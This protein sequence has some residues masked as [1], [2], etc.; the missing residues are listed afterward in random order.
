MTQEQLTPT[1]EDLE[2]LSR[3]LGR[4]A[5][6]VVEIG[7]RCVCGNPLVATTAPRLSNGIP[8][9]TTYYLAHPVITAAVSRLEAAGVMNEMTERLEQDPEL[10]ARYRAAHEAYLQVRNDIGARTG[11]GPVPEID[12]VS[13]GGMPTRV[14]CLHVL[15]GHSL[16]AGP[17]VNPLGDEALERISPWWTRDRCYCDGAWDT[18]AAAPSRDLSRHTKTQGLSAEELDA[19]RAAR[20]EAVE[21]ANAEQQGDSVPDQNEAQEHTAT[22]RVAAVDCGTNSIRLLI[23]DVTYDGGVPKLTDVVRLMRVNRLGQGVDATGRLAPEALE[24]TFEAADEYAALIREH[25]AEQVRFVAT[26]ASRDAENRSEFVDGIRARLGVEPEVI[27]GDEE[28]ALSFAGATSVL[29]G[30]NGTKTLV[31]DLGGGSTEFVLG[32]S[33]GVLAAKST[34]MGCV[35]FTERHLT[36]NPPTEAEIAV[37]RGDI[38]DMIAQVLTTVPLAEAHRLVGVAGTITTVTAHALHLPE[39]SAEAIHGTELDV[40]RIDQAADELLHMDRD[41]R[42]AL[43][44]MHP[45]RVDVIGAGALIWQTIVDRVAELTDGSV[46]TAVTSEHDILDG[47][48]L[49]AAR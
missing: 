5:R 15:V 8:F 23:A 31:V 42:A 48:A 9:P 29:G 10:A 28:A 39:Y 35:R 36:S 4:P 32:T 22:K 6:D 16:A 43:P 24:R 25:G 1:S 21:A 7:A 12:G 30:S 18:T 33:E 11:V 14:K 19:K 20:R 47:I 37:A 40:A 27:T 44:Y 13:A 3:Q 45:G 41:S 34:D 17:G 2:T 26:S 38:L 46:S 49:S